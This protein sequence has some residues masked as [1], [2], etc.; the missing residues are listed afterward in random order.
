MGQAPRPSGFKTASFAGP[1]E[2]STFSIKT[3]LYPFLTTNN[4]KTRSGFSPDMEYSPSALVSSDKPV[5]GKLAVQ[6]DREMLGLLVL[7][8]CRNRTLKP[9]ERIVSSSQ[10]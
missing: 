7:I 10:A 6:S 8:V 2:G 5:T 1:F 3:G 9:L 4:L